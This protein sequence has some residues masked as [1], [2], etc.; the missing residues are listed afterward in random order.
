MD[1]KENLNIEVLVSTMNQVDLSLLKKMNIKS[2]VIIANQAFTN[3]VIEFT[4]AEHEI[5][6]ITTNLRGVGKNRNIGLFFSK[7]DI[8]ILADDDE[9]LENDYL[10][11]VTQAF[12]NNP[13]VDIF[14]FNVE[15]ENNLF[16]VNT[17]IKKV[18]IYNLLNYGAVRIAFRREAIIKSN[19]TF[20]LIFGGG[21]YF[22]SGEDTLFLLDA[23]RSNL[24]I[25]TH[26]YKIAR[27]NNEESSWFSGYNEHYFYDKGKLLRCGFQYFTRIII[28]IYWL[29][30]LGYS[31]ISNYKT[32][33]MLWVGSKR[34]NMFTYDEYVYKKNENGG[35]IIE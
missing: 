18:K 26:P 11:R 34:K 15:S 24:N 21:T 30:S 22:G 2:N 7:A 19:I 1:N 31:S 16:R 25:Y 20:S 32:L 17:K 4:N 28:I 29:K 8:C 12:L 35:H 33:K 23:Y 10:E 6:M 13:N 27:L 9:V 5:T 3:N 14:I